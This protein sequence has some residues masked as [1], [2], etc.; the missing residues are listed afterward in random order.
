M[1]E[2]TSDVTFA[3]ALSDFTDLYTALKVE[4][5]IEIGYQLRD[6]IKGCTFKTFNCLRDE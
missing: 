2:N 6:F 3:Y 4:T 5:R 1:S